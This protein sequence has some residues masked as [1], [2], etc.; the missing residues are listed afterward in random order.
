MMQP[1]FD[2]VIDYVKAGEEDLDMGKMLDLHPDGQELL[3]QAR[4]ICK[5]L[6]HQSESADDGDIAASFGKL[7]DELSFPAAAESVESAPEPQRDRVFYQSA[8]GRFRPEQPPFIE[9]LIEDES[10]RS[11]DLG[12]LEFATKGEQVTFS[13]EPSTTA[14][15]FFKGLADSEGIQIPARRYTLSL[16]HMQ[17]ADEP[18]VIRVAHRTKNTP[19]KSV[20]LI[21]M[22]ESGPFVRLRTDSNGLLVMRVPDQ[23]GTLRVETPIPQILHIKTKK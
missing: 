11:E 13:Y 7:A 22:P 8:P 20:N 10:R 2:D 19:A 23:A 9:T 12:T 15:K 6:Q 18:V 4:F 16:P 3:K 17:Q 14:M 1:N 21:F 5:M